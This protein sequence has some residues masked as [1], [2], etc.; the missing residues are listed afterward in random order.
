M[1]P[2]RPSLIQREAIARLIAAH[3][4]AGIEFPRYP[5]QARCSEQHWGEARSIPRQQESV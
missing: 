1:R 5:E 4:E 2:E 3:R